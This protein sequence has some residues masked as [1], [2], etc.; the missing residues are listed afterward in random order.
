MVTAVARQH[1]F[2]GSTA[3]QKAGEALRLV[4]ARPRAAQELALAARLQA[5]AEDDRT[6]LSVAEEALGLA[7]KKLHE[8]G[9]AL[10]HL[11]AAVRIAERSHLPVRAAEARISLVAVLAYSGDNQAALE[12]ANRAAELL[13]GADAAR[14]HMQRGMVLQRLGRLDEARE[15]YRQALAVFRRT[16]DTRWEARLLCN[17]GVMFAYQGAFQ[18]AEADLRRA[19]RLH[20][21]LGEEFAATQV[22][23]NLGFVA[24]RRG[25]VPAALSWFD[26]ADEYFRGQGMLDAVGLLDRCE[27]LLSVRLVAEARQVA[28]Q[29]VAALER[30]R[31]VTDLAEARLMLSQAA[32]LD[33]D[34]ASAR[35]E[36]ERARRA[37]A[38]QGRPAWSALARYASLRASWVG[39]ERSARTLRKAS[40]T[41]TTLGA[42]G[43]TVPA[44]DAHVIAAR[45]ALEL[46]RLEVARAELAQASRARH[47]GPVEL[48]SCAWHAEALLRLATGDR[49][50][51]DSA[52]RAGL[53]ILD[54]YRA[55]L[56]A[57]DLRVH[58]SG[59][60]GDLATL[61][62]KLALEDRRPDRVLTWAERWRASCL[63]LRP[64]RPSRDPMLASKMA[65][66]RQVASQVEEATLAGLNAS[67]L[68]HRQAALEETIHRRARHVRGLTAAGP[69]DLPAV[70]A[71]AAALGERVLLEL[72]E[73]E[74]KLHGVVI[75]GRR[76]RLYDLATVEEVTSELAALRF[77]LRRLAH[78]HGSAASLEAAERA[79]AYAAARL[80]DLLT[81][82]LRARLLER[83]LV[84]VPT[85]ALH[86]LPWAALPSLAGRPLTVT[87]AAAFW[88]AAQGGVAQAG[89]AGPPRAPASG[90]TV[91]VAG[92]G[93][94]H[95]VPEIDALA[96]QYPGATLLRHG[97]A[98]VERTTA[99]LDGAD[100]AHIAAHGSF[101][102]DNP[103]FSF[104]QLADGRLTVYDL[105]ALERAPT[106]LVLS[107]C[108]S[109]LSSVSPGD[110]LMGLAS[111][112]FALGTRTLVA[113]VVPV[114]DA[115][116]RPLMLTVH[117]WLRTG[118]T[119]SAAL[120]KAQAGAATHG[121]AAMAAAAGFVCFGAG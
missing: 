118:L 15:S 60:G 11:R 72:I 87:P 4:E 7:A 20:A 49:R 88:H 2:G 56:G 65:E 37:F 100:L 90:R 70:D 42:A 105:Q 86:A 57:T 64:A 101:R 41:A 110:E 76:P 107:A 26:L 61:G 103:L 21:S 85:G 44:L 83:P 73:L 113:S 111:A 43:W 36:A 19:E 23:S 106:T 12:E 22:R 27:V 98:T 109:G 39:G 99:A 104:L 75:D 32:L 28:G 1:R 108:E 5:R 13:A 84:V 58:V 59:H 51:A 97:H 102:A 96:L 16:G 45:V 115:A 89:V 95:A 78:G 50:G 116:T 31:M 24:G 77:A 63:R 17:R 91:L 9:V 80:D 34:V 92:P 114:P 74:G 35:A 119:P 33:G 112:L 46:G 81:R 66:L 69:A 82:P 79:A 30:G 71:L 55:A 8:I 25:D 94:P 48:R 10:A 52:L 40:Q 93:L 3:A 14:L 67:R 62:L 6:V 38:A 18:L 53:R 120:A 121:L 54:R 117:R 68:L 47:R 29:A